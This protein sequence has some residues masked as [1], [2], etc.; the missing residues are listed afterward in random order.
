MDKLGLKTGDWAGQPKEKKRI[1]MDKW[2]LKT[3]RRAV[4][5]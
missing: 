2:G 5:P 4:Q 3:E 1:Q